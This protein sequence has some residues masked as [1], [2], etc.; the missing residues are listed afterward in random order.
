MRAL[1]ILVVSAGICLSLAA[2]SKSKT[3]ESTTAAVSE[4]G[5]AAL[6]NGT[7]IT[8]TDVGRVAEGFAANGA[9]PD[10]KADGG[11]FEEK[12][13]YT[14]VNRLVEQELVM[15]AAQAQG[16]I[17]TEEE[18]AASLS[19]LKA[20]SGGEEA[21]LGILAE[22]GIT[23]DEVRRDMRTNLTLQRYFEEV[24]NLNSPIT[25]EE[26]QAYYDDHPEEFGPQGEAHARHILIR[27]SPEM[28]EMD[29]AE[30]RQKAE[31]ARERAQGGEDF[32]ALALEFS[33]DPTNSQTGGDLGWFRRGDMVAPFD[34]AAFA[35][36]AGEV[37]DVI[38][39]SFGYHVI[40]KEGERTGEAREFA[41]V[42]G[43]IRNQMAGE[44]FRAAVDELRQTAE[45]TVLPPSAEIL[46]QIAS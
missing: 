10:P 34:S 24:V 12:M 1:V 9:P 38:T 8:M 6:V 21:F 35:L 11:T 23:E 5:V 37:S 44:R 43:Y 41:T 15:E 45:I 3:D 2:C 17:V 20:M 28:S 30:A 25:D 22:R 13:Y 16:L 18:V 7:T 4:A 31:E 32:S 46:G 40:L 33:E 27:T 19:Q 39:T 29:L 26:V 14:A 42:Q 36:E